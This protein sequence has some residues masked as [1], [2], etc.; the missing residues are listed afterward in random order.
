MAHSIAPSCGR[1]IP[2]Q[3]WKIAD[4]DN[5]GTLTKDEYLEYVEYPFK[6]AD[7]DGDGTIDAKEGRTHAGRVLLRLLRAR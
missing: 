3:D 4:P 2:V 1:R 7:T 5:D 6:R